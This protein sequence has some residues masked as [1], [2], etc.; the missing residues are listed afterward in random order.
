MRLESAE[1]YVSKLT[2]GGSHLPPW[3]VHL[4]MAQP[5]IRGHTSWASFS[6]GFS[7]G[8]LGEEGWGRKQLC[9]SPTLLSQQMLRAR[10]YAMDC[11]GTSLMKPIRKAS[12]WVSLEEVLKEASPLWLKTRTSSYCHK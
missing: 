8:E 7:G 1:S 12:E 2:P 9:L 10:H 11:L 6:G 3:Q 5:L 4:L